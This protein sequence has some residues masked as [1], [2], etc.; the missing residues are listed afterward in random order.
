M[1][2]WWLTLFSIAVIGAGARAQQRGLEDATFIRQLFDSSLVQGQSWPMLEHLCKQIGHR[3]S[4]SEQA[5]QAVLFTRNQML[6]FGFDS[7]WLQPVMVP[8]WKRGEPEQAQIRIYKRTGGG[9]VQRRDLPVSVLALGGSVAT[10][11]SGIEAEVVEFA[12]LRALEAAQT[13]ELEGKIAFINEPFDPRDIY[14]FSSYSHCVGNRLSGA[15]AAAEKGAVAVLVRSLSHR[16]DTYPHT[17]LMHYGDA[18]KR[19]PAAAI[20]TQHAELLSEMLK[21]QKGLKFYLLQSCV[22]LPDTLSY[23]VVGQMHGSMPNADYMVVGGHLDSWDVG[24]GAHDDGVGCVHS[25]EALRL[26]KVNGYRPRH[27]LRAIMFMNEENGMRGATEYA[28]LARERQEFHRVAI[29]SDR[30][31]FSPREFHVDADSQAIAALQPYLPLLE[32]YGIHGIKQGGS[33][34]DVSRLRDNAE[35]LIGFVPDS[36]RY[37]DFHHAASDVLEAVNRRELELGSAAIAALLY[38]LDRQ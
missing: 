4:G 26:L 8:V 34:A 28:R 38:L 32:P 35:L 13:A 15:K 1:K 7:V 22:Q 6:R 2:N 31:G 16:I 25:I 37:F 27:H 20:S 17:G 5:H 30:G 24:E 21:S 9:M 19:I 29:E 14:T 3:L 33:G 23:N 36:Q 10:P 11:P 12:S 18:N